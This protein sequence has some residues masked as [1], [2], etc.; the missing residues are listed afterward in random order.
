MKLQDAV[1]Q[2]REILG[3]DTYFS[4]GCEVTWKSGMKVWETSWFLYCE[5]RRWSDLPNLE[6]VLLRATE[7][8]QA[9]LD[10]IE[11]IEE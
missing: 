3:P 4:V 10:G 7:L 5:S 9:T 6:A 1:E 11:D 8:R 2:V